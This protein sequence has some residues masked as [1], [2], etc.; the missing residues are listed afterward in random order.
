[1]SL[2]TGQ[3]EY[4]LEL[5]SHEYVLTEKQ[6]PLVRQAICRYATTVYDQKELDYLVSMPQ[7]PAAYLYYQCGKESFA[8]QYGLWLNCLEHNIFQEIDDLQAILINPDPTGS[9]KLLAVLCRDDEQLEVIPLP[10]LKFSNQAQA[11]GCSRWTLQECRQSMQQFLRYA[12]SGSGAQQIEPLTWPDLLQQARLFPM[13]KESYVFAGY[14]TGLPKPSNYQ[15]LVLWA[16]KNQQNNVPQRGWL[17][18]PPAKPFATETKM[19][20]QMKKSLTTL[21]HTRPPQLPSLPAPP[22]IPLGGLPPFPFAKSNTAKHSRL[23]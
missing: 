16:A 2:T 7:S 8:R 11:A 5:L 6:K 18:Q 14:T 1:M 21:Q 20:Q 23:L 22:Q 10:Q 17:H 12:R 9:E 15:Q 19:V 4:L 13:V 3:R